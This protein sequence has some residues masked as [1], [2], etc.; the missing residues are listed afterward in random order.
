M[1]LVILNKKL[2]RWI[3]VAMKNTFEK[4]KDKNNVKTSLLW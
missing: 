3:N 1:V 4:L 2:W